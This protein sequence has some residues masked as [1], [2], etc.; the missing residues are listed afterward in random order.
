MSAEFEALV[1]ALLAGGES[2]YVEFKSAFHYGPEGKAPRELASVA[3]DIAGAVVAF[4][5]SDGGDL[6]VGAE[7]SGALTG[8]PWKGDQLNYLLQVPASRVTGTVSVKV[9]DVTLDGYRVLLYRVEEQAGP[10]LVTVGGRCLWRKGTSTE[11]VPPAEIERRR[12]SRLGDTTYEAQPVP[13]AAL[14]DLKIPWGDVG[15]RPSLRGFATKQDLVGLLRYWNLL[16]ARNGSVVLRRAA[17]L[18]F[19]A[20]PLR[21]HPNNRVRVRRV[22][23]E[24]EGFGRDLRTHETEIPGPIC[25]LPRQ[26]IARLR[27]SI[28]LEARRDT[29]FSTSQLLPAEAVDECVVNAV[30][31]RNY[32]IE[33]SAIEVLLYPDRVEFRSPGGLPEPLLLEDLRQQR[34]VHRARNPLIMRVLRDLGWARDQGEGMRRIFGA[35]SQVEL[36]EPGLEVSGDTFILRLSTVSRYDEVT[37]AWIAAYGP[38]GLQPD[39]RKYMVELRQQRGSLSV[40]RLAR[41]LGESYD[42]TKSS[43]ASLD[44]K[45]LVWHAHKSRT[46]RLVEPLKVPLERAYRLLERAGLPPDGGVR[47]SRS[48]LASLA[49]NADARGLDA[50]LDRFRESGV[51]TPAGKGRWR[52]GA[53]ILEYLRDRGADSE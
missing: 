13:A 33:G 2:Y 40:D 20:D 47:L 32:A 10:P 38:F 1:R 39:E 50:L 8:I 37:Q 19:G 48:D 51:L 26:A 53:S 17:L 22:L 9:H 3:G 12:S 27:S 45:G 42:Q 14:T 11:P 30:A 7:D 24:A 43:L 23:G 44:A 15:L 5:N 18:L 6:V 4:G 49:G 46:Y 31:H 36:H 28:E 16:E 29:L 25:T 41:A 34:G 52:F 21:W 35:M